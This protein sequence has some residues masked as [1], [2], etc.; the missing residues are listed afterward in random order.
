MLGHHKFVFMCVSEV[1]YHKS[2]ASEAYHFWKVGNVCIKITSF[3]QMQSCGIFQSTKKI[4]MLCFDS[5]LLIVTAHCINFCWANY[6]T[7]Y[8]QSSQFM[9]KR[10]IFSSSIMQTTLLVSLYYNNKTSTWIIVWDHQWIIL[11][12]GRYIQITI[13]QSCLQS[14]C[15]NITKSHIKPHIRHASLVVGNT[16]CI[17]ELLILWCKVCGIHINFT[18]GG[19]GLFW[20]LTHTDS[21]LL[22][23]YAILND[24]QLYTSHFPVDTQ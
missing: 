15:D 13:L 9:W 6:C 10:K 19:G 14:E 17:H 12:C 22:G 1:W 23:Y 24:T 8:L 2:F 20:I 7:V 5:N 11:L 21:S 4:L 16:K 3:Y 18:G